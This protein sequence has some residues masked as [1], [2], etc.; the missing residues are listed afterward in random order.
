[1]AKSM[2]AP[3][4]DQRVIDT[5]AG[6]MGLHRQDA[7]RAPAPTWMANGTSHARY[8]SCC[9][10]QLTLKPSLHNPR[11]NILAR[12]H[13]HPTWAENLIAICRCRSRKITPSWR[14]VRL[15]TAAAT[16]PAPPSTSIIQLARAQPFFFVSTCSQSGKYQAQE[17]RRQDGRRCGTRT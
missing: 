8:H 14:L 7:G 2:E 16:S 13:L 6:S 3:S 1:M 5:G 12:S 10:V 11:P 15:A 9:S 4:G 17:E